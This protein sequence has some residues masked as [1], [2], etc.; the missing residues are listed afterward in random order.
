KRNRA[1]INALANE[2]GQQCING[3]KADCVEKRF[4]VTNANS[5]FILHL[6]ASVNPKNHFFDIFY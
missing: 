4:E 1:N 3:A 2:N 5:S 6:N